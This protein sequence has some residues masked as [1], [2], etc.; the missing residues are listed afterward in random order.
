MICGCC[1]QEQCARAAPPTGGWIQTATGRRFDYLTPDP[2]SICIEDIAAALSR[3]CRYGGHL[4]LPCPFYS[5]AEHSVHVLSTVASRPLYAGDAASL[6]AALL[7]DA[8]E[9]YCKDIPRPLKHL[10]PGYRAVE[11]RV[12]AAVRAKFGITHEYDAIVKWADDAV[13]RA[14]KPQVQAVHPFPG[15]PDPGGDVAGIR[16]RFLLPPQA[17]DFFL[18]AWRV[19][20][21]MS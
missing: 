17:M 16:V 10:L 3:E 7:H 12:D 21:A 11:D 19:L 5:V 15:D 14:E 1:G 2:R 13:L 4:D 8:A 20:E 6:R 18:S 9:A